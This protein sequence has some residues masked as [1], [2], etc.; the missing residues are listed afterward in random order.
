MGSKK[1]TAVSIPSEKEIEASALPS[2]NGKK[3][4]RVLGFDLSSTCVGWALALD[5]KILTYGKYVFKSTAKLGEKANAF[6]GFVAVLLDTYSPDVLLVEKPLSGRRINNQPTI[7]LVGV[8][9]ELW[10]AKTGSEILKSWFLTAKLV[11]L[12]LN[13]PL[14]HSHDRNKELMVSKINQLLGLKLKYDRNSK[15]KSDDDVAD[16]IGVVLAYVKRNITSDA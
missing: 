7:E 12:R 6:R 4:R 1:P 14:G 8:L 15:Y 10:F 11:K 16:A 5:G 9:R 2:I 13:V 3:Q